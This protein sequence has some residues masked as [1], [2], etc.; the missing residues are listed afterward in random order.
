[1]EEVQCNETEVR[2]LAIFL[3]DGATLLLVVGHSEL[4][5]ARSFLMRES[6]GYI[7]HVYIVSSPNTM[8][9]SFIIHCVSTTELSKS[10]E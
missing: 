6:P 3:T 5:A 4:A 9:A 1:M 2:R 7:V 10:D 8:A